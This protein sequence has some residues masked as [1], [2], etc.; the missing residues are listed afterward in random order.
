MGTKRKVK[1]PRPDKYAEKVAINATF[2]EAM[3]VLADHANKKVEDVNTEPAISE[4]TEE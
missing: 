3:Q 2:E 4:P 1:T